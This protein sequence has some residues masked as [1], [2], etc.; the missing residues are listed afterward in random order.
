M[1]ANH[2]DSHQDSA[3]TAAKEQ[4]SLHVSN[5][6][7]ADQNDDEWM[8]S[9]QDFQSSKHPVT[10]KYVMTATRLAWLQTQEVLYA[11]RQNP[12]ILSNDR[13]ARLKS[14]GFFAH[15]TSV[16]SLPSHA[17]PIVTV[18]S[19]PGSHISP[20]NESNESCS[21]H[22]H[23]SNASP[24]ARQKRLRLPIVDASN[25]ILPPGREKHCCPDYESRQ[26][27][28]QKDKCHFIHLQYPWGHAA[29]EQYWPRCSQRLP[30]YLSQRKYNERVLCLS[31]FCDDDWWYTARYS[32]DSL[33]PA[34]EG[35]MIVLAEG[36]RTACRSEQGIYWYP[37][38]RDAKEALERVVILT[39]WASQHSI[40][41][42]REIVGSAFDTIARKFSETAAHITMPTQERK[43]QFSEA[44]L[45]TTDDEERDRPVKLRWNATDRDELDGFQLTPELK[46]LAALQKQVEQ[47][48]S[49]LNV[50]DMLPMGPLSYLERAVVTD[51]ASKRGLGYYIE[52]VLEKAECS[53]KGSLKNKATRKHITI[54]EF[55][56][57][58]SLTMSE[59]N[60][61]LVVQNNMTT[62]VTM[63]SKTKSYCIGAVLPFVT[64][65]TNTTF[66][67]E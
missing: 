45:E 14:L 24:S 44:D 6:D 33:D 20:R 31:T 66:F 50:G 43:R 56:L 48:A 22:S 40:Q 1:D 11:R 32:S 54:G 61:G 23:S 58:A 21:H 5:E 55:C 62:T 63:K 26:C 8:T 53:T 29:I 19:T 42:N 67:Q 35:K 36:G 27:C 34:D 49:S 7:F 46:R 37:W 9:F 30:S 47:L 4:L 16:S 65:L 3:A 59:A 39:Y 52:L 38:E 2:S 18:S 12:R 64:S 15:D 60:V 10:G 25:W 28:A 13:L 17:E 57:C 51:T 41:A